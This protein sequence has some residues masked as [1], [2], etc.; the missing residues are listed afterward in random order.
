VLLVGALES[1]LL[2]LLDKL[3]EGLLKELMVVV[4]LLLEE[5]SV[6]VIS[7]DSAL[8][9]TG[10]Q[11]V[12]PKVATMFMT[13]SESW[14]NVA[15]LAVKV[16]LLNE[17]RLPILAIQVVE[18]AGSVRDTAN[19]ANAVSNPIPTKSPLELRRREST[20]NCVA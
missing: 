5:I 13:P 18:I 20:V 2:V 6:D 12:G 10:M 16:R 19:G 15:E 3:D 17:T 7:R 1:V 14:Q 4:L 11:G 9:V 8:S